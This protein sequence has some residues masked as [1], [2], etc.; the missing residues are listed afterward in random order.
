MISVLSSIKLSVTHFSSSLQPVLLGEAGGPLLRDESTQHLSCRVHGPLPFATGSK[1][2]N[3]LA[4][5]SATSRPKALSPQSGSGQ[6][7]SGMPAGWS[8]RGLCAGEVQ[9]GTKQPKS[10]GKASE[11][12]AG[13]LPPRPSR[14]T[15]RQL[16]EK[17]Y[18]PSGLW[19]RPTLFCQRR[20]LTFGR[21]LFLSPRAGRQP[22][23]KLDQADKATKHRGLGSGGPSFL[24]Q[25]V[26]S[27]YF[28]WWR[29]LVL[30]LGSRKQSLPCLFI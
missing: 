19:K 7:L 11:V 12:N 18:L 16:R 4:P 20:R 23:R 5:E 13:L 15:H 24:S 8:N 2:I 1:V 30:I 14:K 3:S 21:R 26:L 6:I 9:D 28:Q 10:T 25:D 27:F 29:G 22:R 17:E